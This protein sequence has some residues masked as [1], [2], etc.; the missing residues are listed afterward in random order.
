MTFPFSLMRDVLSFAGAAVL[1]SERAY[2]YFDLKMILPC[3]RSYTDTS[4]VTL[5]PG[6]I[7]I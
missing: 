5:S 1:C 6:K 4:T 7:L 3:V 2:R